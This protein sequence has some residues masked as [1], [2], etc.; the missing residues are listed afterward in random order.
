MQPS[1]HGHHKGCCKGDVR[2]CRCEDRALRSNTSPYT[3]FR[4]FGT[5]GQMRDSRLPS[6][7]IFCSGPNIP[8]RLT[9]DHMACCDEHAEEVSALSLRFATSVRHPAWRTRLRWHYETTVEWNSPMLLCPSMPGL[10]RRCSSGRWRVWTSPFCRARLVKCGFAGCARGAV[11]IV[12]LDSSSNESCSIICVEL[13]ARGKGHADC[14]PL[15]IPT[16]RAVLPFS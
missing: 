3:Q 6:L 13:P 1:L 12:A 9:G 5:P 10:R 14:R 11:E 2:L 4:T 7:W 8:V 16:L 15:F